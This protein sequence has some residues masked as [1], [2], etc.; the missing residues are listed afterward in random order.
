M[1]VDACAGSTDLV[2]SIDGAPEDKVV[3]PDTI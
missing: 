1:L 3:P 2:F